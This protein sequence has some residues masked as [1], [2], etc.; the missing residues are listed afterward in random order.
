LT[1]AGIGADTQQAVYWI[2]LA[3]EKGLPTANFNLG[4]MYMNGISV[5]WDPFKSFDCFQI[6]AKSGM[7]QAEYILGCFIL[8]ILL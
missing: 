7:A 4:I 8:I 5:K 1:G 3:A 2:S 6:A